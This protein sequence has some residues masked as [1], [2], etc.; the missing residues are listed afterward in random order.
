MKRISWMLSFGFVFIAFLATTAFADSPREQLSQM[1]SQ[2]QK[3]PDDNALR[4]KIIKFAQEMKP[5]PAVPEEAERR[6]ARGTAA[7]ES[8][9]S[10]TDFQS[11]AKEF[12]QA[13]L[14]APWSG[15]AYLNL[16]VA[17][18]KAENYEAALRSLKLA[19]L[20]LPD[21]KEIKAL[22]FKVEYRNEKANSPE[23]RAAQEKEKQDAFLRSLDGAKFFRH[24]NSGEADDGYIAEVHGNTLITKE[25]LMWAD[26][27]NLRLRQRRGVKPDRIGEEVELDGP[28]QWKNGQFVYFKRKETWEHFENGNRIIELGCDYKYTAVISEDGQSLTKTD[29]QFELG[30]VKQMGADIVYKYQRQ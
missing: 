24:W 1:V 16:G 5:A 6:M 2:L 21:D 26:P 29:Q 4:E 19:L 11:A 9:H 17:Q 28:Y 27:E 7:F 20:A 10:I 30:T 18:D 14:A 12:E 15:N 3:T 13:T 25:R 23:V 8:A 22:I